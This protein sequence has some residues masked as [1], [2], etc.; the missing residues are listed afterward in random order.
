MHLG[1][2]NQVLAVVD[3]LLLSSLYCICAPFPVS[4][5]FHRCAVV[6]HLLYDP[7]ILVVVLVFV[8]CVVET[9]L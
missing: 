7:L 9:V 1:N 6:F 3:I 8:E 4:N 2:I 5:I